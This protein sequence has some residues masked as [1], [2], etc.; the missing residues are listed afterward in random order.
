MGE[1]SKWCYLAE[2]Y[3]FQHFWEVKSLWGKG[4]WRWQGAEKVRA[5]RVQ[6]KKKKWREGF[7]RP[8][9]P[10]LSFPSLRTLS[11]PRL[12]K[13]SRRPLLLM[14]R[15]SNPIAVAQTQSSALNPLE[16]DC[17]SRVK[18]LRLRCHSLGRRRRHRRATCS[19]LLEREPS[20]RP[21]WPTYPGSH[22]PHV[23]LQWDGELHA[24]SKTLIARQVYS[25]FL[26]ANF[27]TKMVDFRLYILIFNFSLG[28][29]KYF[30]IDFFFFCQL[31]VKD[32]CV[33]FI[34]MCSILHY[35]S[36]KN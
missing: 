1:T 28:S 20:H 2:G 24:N 5:A 33:F 16:S 18:W 27:V 4:V 34:I 6:K 22:W 11:N 32:L 26:M 12:L 23:Y 8:V 25:K 30:W 36:Q 17:S 19:E 21:D 3:I 15:L 14:T 31:L 35:R 29:I 7:P 9:L 13:T 10:L